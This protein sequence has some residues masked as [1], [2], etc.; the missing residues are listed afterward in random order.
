MIA[1]NLTTNSVS[2]KK[3]ALIVPEDCV[4]RTVRDGSLAL[5]GN[6]VLKLD[7]SYA[8]MSDDRIAALEDLIGED[9]DGT[10]PNFVHIECTLPKPFLFTLTGDLS[11]QSMEDV[12]SYTENFKS[13]FE[14]LG[15]VPLINYID[16]GNAKSN[17]RFVVTEISYSVDLSLSESVTIEEADQED[18]EEDEVEEVDEVEEADEEADEVEEP[19]EEVEE[20]AEEVKPKVSGRV[21][22]EDML[23]P[24]SIAAK[25]ST[26]KQTVEQDANSWFYTEDHLT[27]MRDYIK[28]F[29]PDLD[30]DSF[31]SEYQ[32]TFISIIP[33][34][35]L[36]LK[37]EALGVKGVVQP[38]IEGRIKQEKSGE[39]FGLT[40]TGVTESECVQVYLNC[41][42]RKFAKNIAE[43]RSENARWSQLLDS[44]LESLA[45]QCHAMFES[46][47]ANVRVSRTG[48]TTNI[49]QLCD[50]LSLVS[51]LTIK[52]E[53]IGYEV[54]EEFMTLTYNMSNTLI[55]PVCN[56]L[57][58]LHNPELKAVRN[59]TKRSK[60]ASTLFM[61]NFFKGFLTCETD[62]DT[63]SAYTVLATIKALY[64]RDGR[65]DENS[66][67]EILVYSG[68]VLP[69]LFTQ[70]GLDD[71]YNQT[72][73]AKVCNDLS[74]IYTSSI[75]DLN[76][77]PDS[78]TVTTRS[79][80][81]SKLIEMLDEFCSVVD[82]DAISFSVASLV[83]EILYQQTKVQN[84]EYART[85]KSVIASMK[86]LLVALNASGDL[87]QEVGNTRTTVF[88]A[89]FAIMFAYSAAI[90]EQ[91]ITQAPNK[92]VSLLNQL[93]DFLGVRLN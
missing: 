59:W 24:T 54:I 41:L 76:R 83:T 5:V 75:E 89:V 74:A 14:H 84:S 93:G 88:D 47:D 90:S 57:A 56:I 8:T 79:K 71:I 6:S 2:V 31:I 4:M 46:P 68:N 78:W 82:N 29:D 77:L 80:N 52:T 18:I 26:D 34:Y 15:L 7:D 9:T 63:N 87:E 91:R 73:G 64:G 48:S 11:D 81:L 38:N 51:C 3:F 92:N 10:E 70:L 40:L 17:W 30:F 42:F 33:D 25:V 55:D 43:L 28:S 13:L 60:A 69:S 67:N 53:V 66:A 22:L 20:P 65:F 1:V 45:D 39:P 85:Q 23:P 19:A 61:M 35:I 72:V 21:S 62:F 37:D 12:L 44:V 86:Q 27:G 58:L 50:M 36:Y 16:S 49:K 32:Q